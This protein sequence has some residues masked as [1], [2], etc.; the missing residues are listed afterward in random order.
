MSKMLGKLKILTILLSGLVVAACSNTSND[1]N[2]LEEGSIVLGVAKQIVV[3][4]KGEGDLLGSNLDEYKI[5]IYKDDVPYAGWDTFADMPEGKVIRLGYGTYT[6]AAWWGE[7]VIAAFDSPFFY[8]EQE[9]TLDN[10]N[11]IKTVNISVAQQNAQI[12]VVYD[13]S[14]LDEY[15]SFK[16][17]RIDVYSDFIPSKT[18]FEYH[19]SE[20]RPLYFRVGK[21]HLRLVLEKEDGTKYDYGVADITDVQA[22]DSYTF[23]LKSTPNLGQAGITVTLNESTREIN[24]ELEVPFDQIFTKQLTLKNSFTSGFSEIALFPSVDRKLLTYIYATEGIKEV[25]F[26]PS[27]LLAADVGLPSEISFASLST[28]AALSAKMNALGFIWPSSLIGATQAQIDYHTLVNHL[29]TET[30]ENYTHNFKFKVTD[31]DNRTEEI[32]FSIVTTPVEFSVP[33]VKD[34]TIWTKEALVDELSS[35]N[36]PYGDFATESSKFEYQYSIDAGANWLPMTTIVGQSRHLTNLPPATTI[37]YRVVY[38]R[39][40]TPTKSFTTEATHQLQY[41]SLDT[42]GSKDTNNQFIGTQE[43]EYWATLNTRT[44]SSGINAWYTKNSGTRV[45]TK[46]G[47]NCAKIMTIGWGSGNTW[48]GYKWSAVVKN[49]SAGQLFLGAANTSGDKT[50]Y[51]RPLGSRPTSMSF[52]YEYYPLNS[53]KMQVVVELFHQDSEGKRTIV[54]SGSFS[55]ASKVDAMKTQTIDISYTNSELKATHIYVFFTNNTNTGLDKDDI[56]KYSNPNRWE[57][58]PLFVDNIELKYSK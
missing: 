51:G 58:A 1:P 29:Q 47:S 21:L 37:Q 6:A 38:G 40:L 9:F 5:S 28:D 14:F 36:F 44:T 18:P 19:S 32:D 35:E 45:E 8:G 41:A 24:S 20:T 46:N 30:M 57:G 27:E 25:V 54:G 17:Y 42:W 4:T 11:E 31:N 48:A 3:E 16:S 13:Q 49:V 39:Y 34:Y 7:D 52:Q 2:S 23:T 53:S 12:K 10:N 26:V 56:D 15:G 50:T 55:S 33:D 22:R 43:N